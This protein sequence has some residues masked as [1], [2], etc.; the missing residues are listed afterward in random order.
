MG[1]EECS[2]TEKGVLSN[3]DHLES[4][5]LDRLR[6]RWDSRADGKM[7]CHPNPGPS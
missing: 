2:A 1:P 6:Q 7:L 4:V 5:V 3:T